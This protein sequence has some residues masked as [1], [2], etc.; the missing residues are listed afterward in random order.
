MHQQL[1]INHFIHVVSRIGS[2][3]IIDEKKPTFIMTLFTIV[4]K[5]VPA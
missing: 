1:N 5:N 3:K 2:W 4:N